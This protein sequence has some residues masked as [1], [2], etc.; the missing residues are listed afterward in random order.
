MLSLPEAAAGA[1]VR[2]DRA[3]QDQQHADLLTSLGGPQGIADSSLPALAF[4]ITYTV[5]GNEIGLAAWVAVGV[6]AL[7]AAVRLLRREPLQFV[8]A[9]FVGV[10]LAAFVADR[11]G[12]AEDFFLPGLLLNAAYAAAYLVSIAIRWP[13]LGV[14][15]GPITG[16]GMS[17][18]SDPERVRLYTRAS[19]IWV[20]VFALR[21]A[22]QLPLYLAGAVLAL[23]IAK[24][25]MGLPIFL[26]AIWL[27]YLVLRGE[28]RASGGG[29]GRPYAQLSLSEFDQQASRAF[30]ERVERAGERVPLGA[31]DALVSGDPPRARARQPGADAVSARPRPDRAREG[32]SAAQAQDAGVHRPRGRPLPDPAHAH[33]RDLLHRPHGGAG[34]GAERGPD[35]GDR[36][37]PRPRAT[38]RS[39][40]S[41]R[42]RSTRRCASA[43]RRG[44]STTG[45]RCGWST[46]SSATGRG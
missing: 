14:I 43:A 10:A 24:T 44:S 2:E 1:A 27:S 9:G 33:A 8:L 30:R 3:V 31:R 19:W 42:R 34:A 7:M 4:V 28:A 12:R 46:C 25:A 36:A 38:R 22:V 35:R 23:G 15:L 20:G 6:G 29:V 45:T 40:T 13:L 37:R 21:L 16:E 41:A 17:W 18:R 39:A 5:G 26:V 32:V 11:T